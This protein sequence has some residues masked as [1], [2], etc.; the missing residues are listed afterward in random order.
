M[1]EGYY[2]AIGKILNKSL[3]Q[4][5]DPFATINK[6]GSSKDNINRNTCKNTTSA[7]ENGIYEKIRCEENSTSMLRERTVGKVNRTFLKKVPIPAYLIEDFLTLHVTPCSSFEECKNAWKV[8]LKRYH[9]DLRSNDVDN[10]EV[11]IRINEA[12]KRIEQWFVR[13]N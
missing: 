11:V 2:E 5:K 13:Q 1:N 12:F 4:G 8:L 9:P 7:N 6:N 3:S 10:S